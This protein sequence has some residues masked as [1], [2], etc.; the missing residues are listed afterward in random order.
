MGQNSTL[1]PKTAIVTE[2]P[3]YFCGTMPNGVSP[4]PLCIFR[5]HL[6][7]FI[8]MCKFMPSDWRCSIYEPLPLM[9]RNRLPVALYTDSQKSIVIPFIPFARSAGTA[10]LPYYVMSPYYNPA[11]R[12]CTT[13]M[14]C[15]GCIHSTNVATFVH[16]C[17]KT[18]RFGAVLLTILAL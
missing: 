17:N 6:Q 12:A 8:K 1:C 3:S 5:K 4:V 15:I 16:N 11:A 13:C 2:K 10:W 18:E 7:I 14:N 9:K